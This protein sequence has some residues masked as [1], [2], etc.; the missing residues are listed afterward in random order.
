[1][2][3]AYFVPVEKTP[4]LCVLV[5][6]PVGKANAAAVQGDPGPK[7][8]DG[9]V[10]LGAACAA[11]AAR[12]REALEGPGKLGSKRAAS[13]C[14]GAHD[15]HFCVGVVTDKSLTRVRGTVRE[16]LKQT[17]AVKKAECEAFTR[18]MG[19]KPAAADACVS[20][21]QHAATNARVV[22]AGP[23][24][25]DKKAAV[26]AAISQGADSAK[27]PAAAGKP[28]APS[29]GGPAGEPTA[30]LV[31]LS[32]KGTAL[33]VLAG[34]L[35]TNLRAPVEIRGD[36][37]ELCEKDAKKA[38]KL[39]AADKKSKL[40]TLLSKPGVAERAYWRACTEAIAVA[41]SP[42]TGAALAGAVCGALA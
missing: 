40:S 42:Q 16:I 38:K 10:E 8:G 20:V 39:G 19:V 7:S 28:K 9:S 37:V 12:I 18:C 29:V 31:R 34:Y 13:V 15:G 11:A 2:K 6:L 33:S 27:L 14:V 3:G 26:L 23:L 30:G 5:C 21:L 32:A 17:A 36:G 41:N 1:M 24:K 25:A 22:V 4:A 35:R